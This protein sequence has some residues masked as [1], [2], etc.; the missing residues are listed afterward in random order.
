MGPVTQVPAKG[1]TVR[2]DGKLYGVTRVHYNAE[3]FGVVDREPTLYAF[4]HLALS[5]DDE[6]RR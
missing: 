2:L 1:D 4:V 6:E 3:R 5:A